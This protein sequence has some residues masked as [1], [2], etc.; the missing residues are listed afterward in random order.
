MHT[1][2]STTLPPALSVLVILGFAGLMFVIVLAGNLFARKMSGWRDIVGRFPMT[3][4]HDAG[5]IYK[6]KSGVFGSMSCSRGLTIRI[7]H[8]GVCI[9]PSFARRNPCLIPW[10]AIRRIS[11]SDTSLLVVVDYERTFEFFLPAESLPTFEAKL[12]SELFHKAVSPFEAA[13]KMIQDGTQPR[14]MS[15]IA[16]QAVRLAEKELEKE[17]QLRKD[18]HDDVV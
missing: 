9:Y 11:V 3:D 2:L 1:M 4:I 13:K 7:A 15:A 17:K 5:D 14:W 8:E 18:G 6:R 16:G 10:S 12:S